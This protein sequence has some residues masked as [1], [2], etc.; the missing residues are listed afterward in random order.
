MG[1]KNYFFIGFKAALIMMIS[2]LILL[3]PKLMAI[4]NPILYLV[5]IPVAWTL[6][7]YLLLKFHKFI[8]NH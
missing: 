1:K 4:E 5:I 6:N 2:G 8:F 7:G 3:I